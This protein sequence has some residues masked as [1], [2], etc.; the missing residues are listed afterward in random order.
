MKCDG[1]L[2]SDVRDARDASTS[3]VERQNLTMRMSISRFT[4][5]TN[6]GHCG[7]Y[8]GPRGCCRE[9]RALQEKS[10]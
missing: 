2:G 9:A 1:T 4:R 8:R 10:R 7:A 6:T 3:Y 5:L